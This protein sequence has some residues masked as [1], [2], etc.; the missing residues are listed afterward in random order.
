[1]RLMLAAIAFLTRL[2][3]AGHAP[4]D[5]K[6]VARSARFFP[7]A[8]ALLGA[9]YAAVFL[10]LTRI[11][12]PL[13]TAVLLLV[14]DALLTGAMHFDGLADTADGFGGGRTPA[15]VL[16][17]MRDPE[18]GSYGAVSVVLLAALKIA[19]LVALIEGH[20]AL[21]ALFLAPVLGR[22][23]AVLLG[24]TQPYARPVAGDAPSTAGAPTR[25]MGKTEL[26]IATLL[27]AAFASGIARWLGGIA[28]GAVAAVSFCWAAYCRHRI[29]G[30]TGDTLGAAIELAECAVLLVFVV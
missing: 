16:R 2:P 23:A 11:F 6:T 8:G 24:A 27:A 12:P 13:L 21:P 18:V 25:H 7:L 4:L 3:A 19:A 1:M 29:G 26:A 14:V 9:I 20:R 5:A 15:D 28:A 30:V 22:W 10:G 17:I